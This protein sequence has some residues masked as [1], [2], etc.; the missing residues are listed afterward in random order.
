MAG[1][2]GVRIV[3]E[4]ALGDSELLTNEVEARDFFRDGVFYLQ[5]GV[6]LE[7]RDGAV[8]ANQELAGSRPDVPDLFQ[9][10]L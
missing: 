1:D 2:L 10:V 6:D 9:D 8:R 5:A 4:S 7:E 3:D